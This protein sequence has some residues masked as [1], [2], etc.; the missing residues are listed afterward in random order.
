MSA[1][2]H[3]SA[4]IEPGARIGDDCVIGAFCCIGPNVTLGPRCKLQ[5]HVV[6]DG[7][8]TIGTDCEFYSFACIGK[9]TQ[10]L[11]WKGGEAFVVIGSRNTFREYV[12]VH[13]STTD[14][15]RT[16]IGDD[17]SILAYCHVA[18]DCVVGSHVVMSNSTHLAGHV[19]IEDRV[20]FGGMGGVAQFNRV[21]CL[22]MVGATSKVVQD[23]APFCL[24]DGAPAVPVT[25]NKVG[26]E[27]AGLAPET[28]KAVTH[29]FKLFFRSN[30]IATDALARL[31]REFP[32]V[33]EVAHFVE[34]VEHS[35]RGV[36]R[37]KAE[38]SAAEPKA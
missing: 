5:S 10:D 27:R 7:H 19:V 38:A 23:V 22:S 33:P 16:V 2:I 3:P 28:I 8:T 9:R 24:V 29:A 17:C 15:G 34:F 37:P 30:L 25:V 32:G 35:K 18:H 14:G 13:A 31:R 11:K 6:L 4:V 26:M 21:G 1:T 20:V 12:T 36:A